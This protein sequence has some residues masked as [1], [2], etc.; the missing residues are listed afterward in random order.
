MRELLLE[1]GDKKLEQRDE[2]GAAE[3]ALRARQQARLDALMPSCG[4]WPGEA[5]TPRDGL[6]YEQK[7]RAE[8]P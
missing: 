3:N 6:L 2:A 8:W 5:G 1:I 7:M 4:I